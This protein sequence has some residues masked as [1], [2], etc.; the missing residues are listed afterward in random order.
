[1]IAKIRPFLAGIVL[2]ILAFLLIP[3]HHISAQSTVYNFKSIPGISCFIPGDKC[4]YTLSSSVGGTL[5][6][7]L[8]IPDDVSG[9]KPADSCPVICPLV[10]DQVYNTDLFFGVW[11]DLVNTNTTFGPSI[12]S[13]LVVACTGRDA[14]GEQWC[15]N[16]PTTN[17]HWT[18]TG[19]N[20]TRRLSL[21]MPTITG[22]PG[23]T[24]AQGSAAVYCNI[25]VNGQ[26]IDIQYREVGGDS[27]DW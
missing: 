21:N 27:T 18:G 13:C 20:I 8:D 2:T 19:D 11:V 6:S 3:S 24:W 7:Y 16:G 12:F 5:T 9:N 17:Y 26:V 1:M 4:N 22:Q 14:N 10:R 23:L 15:F 25:G